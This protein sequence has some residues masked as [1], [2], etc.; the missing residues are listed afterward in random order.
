MLDL[1]LL[2]A[3]DAV[4]RLGTFGRA[5]AELGYTQSS[6]SQ[7]IATLERRVGGAVF[8]RPGGARR[9][10][11]TPLGRLVLS[12]AEPLLAGEQAA[13]DVIDRFH[14]GG[15]RVDVG[16]F[17][18]VTNVI[19][20]DVV[21]RLRAEHPDA[22]IRLFEDETE[23]P[24]LDALDL[25]FLDSGGPDDA[26]RVEVFRDEHV[27]LA[28][29]G[30]LGQGPVALADLDGRAMVALPA[31]CDQAVVEG[32]LD[33]AGVVPDIVFR[34]ADNQG[35]TSMVRAGLGV[36]VMP[37]LAVWGQRNDPALTFHPLEHAVPDRVVNLLSRGTLSPVALRFRE[38]AVDAGAQLVAEL[39]L[40]RSAS[41]PL[42]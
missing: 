18:T 10:L 25:V 27:V 26:D 23:Q 35:I 6:L 1:R 41:P 7:Q 16:T 3:L 22:D 31:I 34:T 11:I 12:Q 38:L 5:A 28:P 17:Q 20:P 39:T 2:A 36:A 21:E 33:A 4:A 9:P 29:R 19:L 14:A 24:P 32:A 30:L 13:R 42:P 15:G 37:V 8:D 40:S